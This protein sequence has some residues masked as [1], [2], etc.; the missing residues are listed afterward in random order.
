MNH[1]GLWAEDLDRRVRR[2]GRVMLCCPAAG[3]CS[4]AFEAASCLLFARFVG[5]FGRSQLA[6]SVAS[7]SCWKSAVPGEDL[8]SGALQVSETVPIL[9]AVLIAVLIAAATAIPA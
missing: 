1:S 3:G 4:K 9:I 5:A 6:R 8:G 7:L 2:L